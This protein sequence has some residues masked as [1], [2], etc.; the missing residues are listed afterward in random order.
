MRRPFWTTSRARLAE[1]GAV[2]G[3]LG[4]LA[5][6]QAP[7]L[8]APLLDSHAF[9]QTQTA[10]S[11][12]EFHENGIDLLHPKLPVLGEPFEAPFEF[13]LF[14]AVAAI[15]M[16]L[17]VEADTALRATA[18]ACFLATALLLFGLVRHV[19]GPVSAVAA[20]V[21]FAV[22]PLALV[23]SRMAMIEYLATAAAVGF[24]W[25]LIVWRE[26]RGRRWG[27]I[28]LVAG[29]VGMLVKPTTAV[30][31][32]LPAL[33]YRPASPERSRRRLHVDAWTVACVVVP[34]AAAA[35]WTRH[36]DAIKAASPTT[37]GLTS[38]NLRHWNFG[39][40]EQ[41]FDI[42]VWE[43][44]L[45]QVRFN[46]VGFLGLLLLPAL[47]AAARS[48]QWLFW[49]GIAS[50][51]ILPPLVFTNLYFIHDY[52]LV[53]LTPALAALIGLG[54]G[55]VWTTLRGHR[56]AVLVPVLG[57]ALVCGSLYIGREYRRGFAGGIEDP[58]VSVLAHEIESRTEPDDLVAIV[59]LEWT[60]AVL[61]YA[62]RR[63]HMVREQTA[64]IAYDLIHRDDYRFLVQVDPTHDDLGFLSRWRWVG[65]L[66]P[67][68][69]A[70][71]DSPTQLSG[72][73]FVSTNELGAVRAQLMSGRPLATG[74]G[75]ITC[76]RPLR[77]PSGRRG[78]WIR[79]AELKRDARVYV[80]GALAPLP[81][82]RL[83]FVA[84][85][86][87]ERGTLTVTCSGT[88]SVAVAEVVDAPGPLA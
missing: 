6:Y 44:I 72:S 16:D 79:F 57:V 81:L 32:I 53:A 20:L 69:Y 67:H 61:Y 66:G 24:T 19:A 5:A 30:F 45:D 58:R 64:R 71:A 38:W 11:A 39:S 12:R 28:A 73:R 41:R 68:L 88:E 83:A 60:P 29:V 14:Q 59:G 3:V 82:R 23:W 2:V 63:G 27:A 34:L 18:L 4:A 25:A 7:T 84:P 35:L 50:A 77:I 40:L 31:W 48:P 17:G 54:A 13:P 65:A 62:H 43:F 26:H 33:A 76:G 37:E 49:A 74:P 42:A 80:S 46:V 75:P 47:V 10:F 8:A 70:I 36:A 21:A 56:L 52:Y 1:A 55:Y 86:L 15:V 51:A 78:T 87:A 85:E 22:T 9:R